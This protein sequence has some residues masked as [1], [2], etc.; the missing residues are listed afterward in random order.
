[1]D[2]DALSNLY[3]IAPLGEKKPADLKVVFSNSLFKCFVYE[4]GS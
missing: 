3:R 1:V 4:G 2:W